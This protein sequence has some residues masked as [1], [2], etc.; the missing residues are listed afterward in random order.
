MSER[1]RP[2]SSIAAAATRSA[3]VLS[4]PPETPITTRAIPVLRKRSVSPAH[5]MRKIS[6]ARS[7]RRSAFLGI[8]GAGSTLAGHNAERAEGV[9]AA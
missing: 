1:G 6:L 9:G 7:R 2:S 5:C 4:R 8:K 3:S